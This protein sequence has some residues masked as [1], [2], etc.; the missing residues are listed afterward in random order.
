MK[1]DEGE[2]T[3]R[4]ELKDRVTSKKR[5]HRTGSFHFPSRKGIIKMKNLM[6]AAR[7]SAFIIFSVLLIIFSSPGFFPSAASAQGL[8]AAKTSLDISSGQPDLLPYQP[9]GWG[10]PW[11][12][13]RNPGRTP[14]TNW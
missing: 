14:M 9:E 1:F 7:K 10:M 11:F 8:P 13:P 4:P 12:S 2:I 5:Y 3:H 6:P